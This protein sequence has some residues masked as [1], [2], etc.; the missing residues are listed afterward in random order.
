MAGEKLTVCIRQRCLKK[1]YALGMVV[2]IASSLLHI[3]RD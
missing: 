2:V 3:I 1:V